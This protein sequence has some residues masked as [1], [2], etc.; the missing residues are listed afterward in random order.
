MEYITRHRRDLHSWIEA[1]KERDKNRERG[2]ERD[3]EN[4]L[5]NCEPIPSSRSASHPFPCPNHQL[6]FRE[7]ELWWRRVRH[8]DNRIQS[9]LRLTVGTI[10]ERVCSLIISVRVCVCVAAFF[11]CSSTE[12]CSYATSG[13]IKR[14][15]WDTEKRGYHLILLSVQLKWERLHKM[16]ERTEIVLLMSCSEW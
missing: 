5:T 3:W 7:R 9:S 11:L 15:Q 1:G 12:S 6:F 16:K 13:D 14:L 10:S 2:K 8:C 4:R